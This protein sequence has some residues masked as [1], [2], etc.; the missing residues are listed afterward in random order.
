[1]SVFA[2]V[3]TEPT[4]H[5]KRRIESSYPN[6]HELTSDVFLVS[7]DEL[8]KDIKEKIGIGA[9]GVDGI[10]FRLNNIY[11]GYTSRDTWEWLSKMEQ[12]T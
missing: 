2:V 3:L 7:S 1:M 8:T 6:Y 4:E 12:T 10:V 5:T 11:S 9:D